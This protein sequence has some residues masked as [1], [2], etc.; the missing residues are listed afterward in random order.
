ME[1]WRTYAA[2]VG[3]TASTNW[4]KTSLEKKAMKSEGG[5]SGSSKTETYDKKEKDEKLEKIEL[6][7]KE[8]T[9]L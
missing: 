4:I 5:S 7:P 9:N 8:K 2:G 6:E 1:Q 3:V